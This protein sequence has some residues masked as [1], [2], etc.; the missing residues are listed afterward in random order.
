MI[1]LGVNIDHVATLRQVR[2]TDYPSPL[3]AAL[4]AEEAGADYITLH[5]REDRRHIQDDDVTAI[6]RALRT[7]MNLESA[8]T[9]EMLAFARRVRPEDVCLVPER[10]AELTTEGGLD[11]AR[12]LKRIEKACRELREAGI[13]V[14]LFIDPDARQVDAAVKAGAPVVE[15]HTGSYAE[16]SNARAQRRELDKLRAAAERAAAKGLHV[17]AGH[18]LNY[19]NVGPV[20]AMA[21]VRELNIGHAIIARSVFVGIA[22]AVREM[23]ALLGRPA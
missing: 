23:K 5:L 11:V 21:H 22:Q 7:R 18:G 9:A 4:A 19:D 14:S 17:N 20:A 13:R 12:N 1:L 8:V 3:E 16:A 6:R 15:L 10:R 2:G